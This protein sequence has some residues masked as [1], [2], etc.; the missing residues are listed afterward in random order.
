MNSHFRRKHESSL[1]IHCSSIINLQLI[2]IHL[3]FLYLKR[4]KILLSSPLICSPAHQT[5]TRA[6]LQL[7][8]CSPNQCW[9]ML[10]LQTLLFIS[11]LNCISICTG[12]NFICLCLHVR[13]Q[14]QIKYH[15][16]SQPPTYLAT[17]SN[18]VDFVKQIQLKSC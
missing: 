12:I 15:A 8:S 3:K 14:M 1:N 7:P 11:L 4:A 18:S 16:W 13:K 10:P 9:M 2:Q 5:V 6:P 17:W